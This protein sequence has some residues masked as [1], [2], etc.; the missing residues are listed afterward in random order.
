MQAAL[1]RKLFL[2]GPT[3]Q[4]AEEKLLCCRS[5]YDSYNQIN[6]EIRNMWQCLGETPQSS[7][8]CPLGRGRWDSPDH[9][10]FWT[11]LA[12]PELLFSSSE[13]AASCRAKAFEGQCSFRYVEVTGA[14]ESDPHGNPCTSAGTKAPSRQHLSGHNSDLSRQR[15]NYSN[16]VARAAEGHTALEMRGLD[17]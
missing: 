8:G 12:E 1:R 17:G 14:E 15:G 6:G 7:Q 4:N 3:V 11:S 10:A 13:M 2:Y 9:T 5:S 16:A